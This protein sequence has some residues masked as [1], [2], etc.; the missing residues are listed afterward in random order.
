MAS[1]S[2]PV[3]A[4]SLNVLLVR[5]SGTEGSVTEALT[6]IKGELIADGF[7]VQL[8]DSPTATS[9]G[10]LPSGSMAVVGLTLD[11]EAHAAQLVIVDRFTNKTLTRR[12]DTR[13][14]PSARIAEVLAVRAVE[15]LRAS[16]LELL[17]DSRRAVP[18]TAADVPLRSE[19]RQKASAWA[20]KP[21]V[22]VHSPMVGIEAGTCFMA[23]PGGLG[24]AL[25]PVARIRLA[26][27]RTLHVR[28]TAGG[29][30]TA[31]EVTGPHGTA[32]VQQRLLLGEIAMLPWPDTR[33]RPTFSLG[34]GALWISVNG[35]ASWPYRGAHHSEWTF[36]TDLGAGLSF[37]L[38]PRLDLAVEAHAFVALPYPVVRFLDTEAARVALPALIGSVSLVGWL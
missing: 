19:V 7:E 37:R 14:E 17:V 27:L 36:A 6:R 18:S 22:S 10:A 12:I 23:T 21:V 25:L 35:D 38:G 16:L 8:V 3:F 31:P 34:A 2:E 32:T 11:T 30:G 9:A 28:A 29:L 5:P 20:E 15:L 24:P 33:V 1:V 4:D 13:R 26:P